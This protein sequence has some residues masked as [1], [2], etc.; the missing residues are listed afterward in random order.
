MIKCISM[1]AVEFI[2][3]KYA[4]LSKNY[5]QGHEYGISRQINCL[6]LPSNKGTGLCEM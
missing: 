1:L 5:N 3:E 2:P 4:T 6:T